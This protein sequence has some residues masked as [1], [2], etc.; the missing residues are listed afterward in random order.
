MKRSLALMAGTVAVVVLFRAPVWAGEECSGCSLLG[1]LSVRLSAIE[2]AAPRVGG[3]VTLTFDVD[4]A[5]PGGFGCS[6]TTC[7]FVGGEP[8][9]EGDEVPTFEANGV[10]VRRR[11]A[12]AGVATV[13]LDLTG[14]TEEACRVETDSGC[15]TFFQPA[16]IHASTGPLEVE[17]LEAPTATPTLT[18]TFTPTPPPRP[19]DDGCAIGGAPRSGM[20]SLALVL[21]P[22]LLLRAR[23]RAR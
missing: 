17:V 9:L 12:E 1:S 14:N 22:L 23:A 20:A 18:P 16:F 5:L 13:R 11:A 6:S 7:D 2:P 19:E 15:S 3:S 10:V 21:A 4:Y 8:V